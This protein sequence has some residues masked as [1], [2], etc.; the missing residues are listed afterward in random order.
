MNRFNLPELTFLDKD[1]E[2]IEREMLLHIEEST[3][4]VF[5]RADPR[6]KFLQSIATYISIE[7]NKL[8]HALRQNRLSYAEDDVLDHM[9]LE[10]ST[11]RLPATAAKT[12]MAFILEPDRVDTLLI[13]KDTLF[14]VGENTYFATDN[15]VLVPVGTNTVTVPA[16]CTELGESG[17]GYL[18]GEI[19]TLVNPLPWVNSVQNTTISSGGADIESDDAYAERIRLAP[20]SFSVAGP[21][22]AYIYW[23]KAFS[24]DIADVK[25]DSPSAG[26]VDIRILMKDGRLPSSAEIT[27]LEN[28]LMTKDIRPLTD[29]IQVSSPTEVSYDAVVDYWISKSNESIATIISQQVSDAFNNYLTWQREKIGRDVDLSEL[30]AKLKAAG[31]S[32]VS[33]NSAM[34]VEIDETAVAKENITTL[35]Y[36]GISE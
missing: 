13:P 35:T 36:R 8:E 33:V 30:I 12:I 24:Q 34:F 23:A 3:G 11:E 4:V 2:V 25:V 1:P 22:G 14:L 15:E 17:N 10:V 16:T 28:K 19:S 9:G 6:R 20:E 32:R 7:R 31:A 5:E 29:L 21:E 26:I 18:I 27:Y